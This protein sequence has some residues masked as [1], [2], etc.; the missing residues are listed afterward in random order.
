MGIAS[1]LYILG[2]GYDMLGMHGVEV[3]LHLLFLFVFFLSLCHGFCARTDML[4]HHCISFS[5]AL[6]YLHFSS[7]PGTDTS[8][9][10]LFFFHFSSVPLILWRNR[11]IITAPPFLLSHH[12]LPLTDILL[13]H[14]HFI[15]IFY[16]SWHIIAASTFSS[17]SP[18]VSMVT[19]LFWWTCDLQDLHV[20]DIICNLLIPSSASP[21]VIKVTPCSDKPVVL[22]VF[23]HQMSLVICS[24][25][26]YLIVTISS[27]RVC[28]RTPM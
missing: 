17:T 4:L 1:Q 18:K 28:E 13:L 21:S 20:P 12:L 6:H 15:I 19:P 9:L 10:H 14:L 23:T 7:S 2:Y 8:S 5:E 16:S 24:F 11:H 22:G 26:F 3:G 25:P 27:C